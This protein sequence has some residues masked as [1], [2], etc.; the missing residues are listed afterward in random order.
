MKQNNFNHI[1]EHGVSVTRGIF[2]RCLCFVCIGIFFS[3]ISQNLPGHQ[4][5]RGF[6]GGN[7]YYK[8][9]NSWDTNQVYDGFF[10]VS[11]PYFRAKT[12]DIYVNKDALPKDTKKKLGL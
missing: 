6:V 1:T 11:E 9:K 7:R 4:A 5:Q 2:I 3:E 8:V 12:I 10:Y